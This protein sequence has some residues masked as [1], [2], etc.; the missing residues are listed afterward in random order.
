V[1]ELEQTV[2]ALLIGRRER[3]LKDDARDLLI[4]QLVGSIR[5]FLHAVDSGYFG[6]ALVIGPSYDRAESAYLQGLR[7][8]LA[9]A[10]KVQP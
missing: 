2:T 6:D 4:E 9:A 8:A 10:K 1:K 3:D 7:T 5:T